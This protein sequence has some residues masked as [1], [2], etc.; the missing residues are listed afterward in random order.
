MCL[1]WGVSSMEDRQK[2]DVL[3]R[4][5]SAIWKGW[6]GRHFVLVFLDF[7]DLLFS[8]SL[9]VYGIDMYM[10]V[11]CVLAYGAMCGVC[12]CSWCHV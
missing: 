5:L 4:A 7:L 1:G 9:C 6:L 8:F 3:L 2:D 12:P 10:C 11:V